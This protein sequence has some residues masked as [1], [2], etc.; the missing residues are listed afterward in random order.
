MITSAE[1]RTPP[2]PLRLAGGWISAHLFHAGSLDALIEQVAAPLAA[3]LHGELAGFFFL[4]YWEGGPHLRLRMKPYEAADAGRIRRLIE[5][6]AGAFFAEHPSQ[7]ALQPRDYQALAIRLA[8]AEGLTAHD[9]R[10][11]PNDA[12]EFIDYLPEHRAYGD[13]ACLAAVEEH[14]TDSSRLALDILATGPGH[15]R[16]AAIGLAAFTLT[17]AACL[18]DRRAAARA[19]ALRIRDIRVPPEVEEAFR[20]DAD[21]LLRQ[22]RMLWNQPAGGPLAAWSCSVRTLRDRLTG[23]GAS[24][25]DAGSSAAFLARVLEPEAVAAPYILLRCTHLLHN[26]L[27]INTAAEGRLALLALRV[28]AAL[29]ES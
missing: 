7:R 12:V 21:G 16:R 26:R 14:F 27:G 15:E 24:P 23:L 3:E 1:P 6:R 4:R 10:L 5:R 20:R 28:I 29:H 2:A 8:G 13:G 18:P 19:L 17:V 11:H 22:T 9:D 25:A